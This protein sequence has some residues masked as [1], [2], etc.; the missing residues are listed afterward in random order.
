MEKERA[1]DVMEAELS[2]LGEE[3][4]V[5]AAGNDKIQAS[6]SCHQTA[7]PGHPS[8]QGTDGE[9]VYVI[10]FHWR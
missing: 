3:L 2:E 8:P 5:E 9:K 4:N 6:E 7:G 10:L 1:Q